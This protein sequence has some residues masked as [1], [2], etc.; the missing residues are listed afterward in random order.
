MLILIQMWK[1]RMSRTPFPSPEALDDEV[2]LE[3]LLSQ[4]EKVGEDADEEEWVPS[5]VRYQRQRHK[6]EK[7]GV[8]T[9]I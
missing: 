4:S 6:E 1:W 9:A 8:C 5:R 2:L 3:K 7:T